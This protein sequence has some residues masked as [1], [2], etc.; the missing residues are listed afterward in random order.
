[1]TVL[2][3]DTLSEQLPGARAAREARAGG[4][5]TRAEARSSSHLFLHGGHVDFSYWKNSAL[6]F[7][8]TGRGPSAP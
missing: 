6:L 1:V 2:F 3:R 7:S 8:R 4:R 5:K